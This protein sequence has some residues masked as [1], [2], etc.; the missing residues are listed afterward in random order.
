ML[1]T[2]ELQ[3][4]GFLFL[5]VCILLHRPFQRTQLYQKLLKPHLVPIL[6]LLFLIIISWQLWLYG[7]HALMMP[8]LVLAVVGIFIGWRIQYS[9]KS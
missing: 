9:V 1:T 3:L 8:L 2:D 5:A 4:L 6:S 7:F